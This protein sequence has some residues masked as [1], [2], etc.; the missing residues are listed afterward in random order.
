MP[1]ELLVTP[2]GVAEWAK[3]LKPADN[4][5]KTAREYSIDLVLD[6]NDMATLEFIGKIE[7]FYA[8]EHGKA[9]VAD[10]GWP[11]SEHRRQDGTL[12]GL[13]RFRFKRNEISAKGNELPA[14]VVVDSKRNA[15][16]AD[17]EIGNGS[18]VRVGYT[19]WG[20]QSKGKACGVSLSLESVQVVDLVPFERVDPAS[21][22]GDVEGGYVAEGPGTE[23]P[24]EEPGK[25][26]SILEQIRQRNAEVSAESDEIP[27]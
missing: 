19:T 24:K 20:W 27:F 15:W 4:F 21:A 25:P 14:P 1:R 2:I 10:R 13:L 7:G 23:F 3:V 12:T 18:K 8:S 26:M 22:F 17:I 9:P 11:Y 5:D 16:P 6:P